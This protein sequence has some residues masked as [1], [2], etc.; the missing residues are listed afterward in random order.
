MKSGRPQVLITAGN[1]R[2]NIDSVRWWSNI[3]TGRTGLDIAYA[4]SSVADVCLLTSNFEHVRELSAGTEP[5]IEVCH[6]QSHADLINMIP[7][8]LLMRKYDAVFMTAAVSDYVPDGAYTVLSRKDSSTPGQEVWTVEKVQQPKISSA[9][10]TLAILGKPTAKVIDQFRT[11]WN[12]RGLLFK[13]KLEVGLDEAEL[14]TVAQASR[15][16]SQADVI[17]ANTLEMVDGPEPSAIII[18]PHTTRKVPRS[19]L[20][21]ALKDEMI[22][23]LSAP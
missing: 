23:R 4:M 9:H 1:T 15:E 14:I 17:V 18:D 13:F 10:Q 12:Y 7:S 11:E 3:F 22:T 21:Q 8:R 20:A 6:F 5:K 19:K 16:H 2:E